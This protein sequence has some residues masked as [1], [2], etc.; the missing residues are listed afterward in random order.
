MTPFIDKQFFFGV[1]AD[2]LDLRREVDPRRKLIE[3]H[4]KRG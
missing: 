3:I 4:G 1:V 2:L